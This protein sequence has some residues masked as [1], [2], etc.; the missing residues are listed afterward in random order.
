MADIC[1]RGRRKEG[2]RIEQEE[3]RTAGQFPEGLARPLG[4]F[5]VMGATWLAGM[6]LP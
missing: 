4:E 6:G 3:F 1:D 5:L 2:K